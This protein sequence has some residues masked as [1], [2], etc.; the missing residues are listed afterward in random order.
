ASVIPAVP[1]ASSVTTIAFI[2]LSPLYPTSPTRRVRFTSIC[3]TRP[4]R[5]PRFMC[6][7]GSPG[8][9]QPRTSH[10][11]ELPR[12]TRGVDYDPDYEHAE[13]PG[14]SPIAVDV[15]AGV[16]LPR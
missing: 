4:D 13:P 8:A 16:K 10:R 1:A 6:C 9:H 14:T 7:D 15:S 5:H 11:P 2:G 12:M 3:G